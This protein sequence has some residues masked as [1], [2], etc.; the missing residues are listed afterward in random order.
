MKRWSTI[1]YVFT[2]YLCCYWLFPV[3]WQLELCAH[4]SL[5]LPALRNTRRKLSRKTVQSSDITPFKNFRD[6]LKNSTA[7]VQENSRKSLTEHFGVHRT[8]PHAATKLS[9]TKLVYADVNSGLIW[10]LRTFLVWPGRFTMRRRSSVNLLS[11]P[12]ERAEEYTDSRQKSKPF[13]GDYVD[14]A[15][16]HCR[17]LC[18]TQAS[19]TI[20]SERYR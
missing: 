14:Y 16:D 17:R 1:L 15:G 13:S 4:L 8:T 3:K 11:I 2:W 9:S 20:I 7:T 6:R 5:R 18:A 12:G 19:H 10:A